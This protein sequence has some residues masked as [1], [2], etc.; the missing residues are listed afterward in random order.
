MAMPFVYQ[1][2]DLRENVSYWMLY[3][4]IAHEIVIY[5]TLNGMNAVK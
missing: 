1:T 4:L 3:L 2:S 5:V